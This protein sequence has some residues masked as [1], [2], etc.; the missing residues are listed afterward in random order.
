M[1]YKNNID[2]VQMRYWP[3]T[4]AILTQYKID[5]DPVQERYWPGTKAILTRYK[6]DT[7]WYRFWYRYITCLYR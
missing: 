1:V 2:P 3:G 6:R 4:K 5:T 7:V